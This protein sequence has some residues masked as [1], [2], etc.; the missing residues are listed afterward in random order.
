MIVEN[1]H[2][3]LHK[4]KYHEPQRNCLY[5]FITPATGASGILNGREYTLIATPG[6]YTTGRQACRDIGSDLA[7]VTTQEEHDFI[8]NMTK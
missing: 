2:Y 4:Q 1:T 3:N 7:V 5:F 8:V 6:N